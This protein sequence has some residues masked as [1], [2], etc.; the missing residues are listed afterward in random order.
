[1]QTTNVVTLKKM[2]IAEKCKNV[3]VIQASVTI[4][5][6]KNGEYFTP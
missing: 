1:M 3:D 5:N 2:E 6:S 4:R